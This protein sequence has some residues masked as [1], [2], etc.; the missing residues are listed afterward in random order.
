MSQAVELRDVRYT[1]P[2]ASAPVLN[3]INFAIA[4]G[5]SLGIIGHNGSGKSTL[6]RIVSTLLSAQ[7]GEVLFGGQPASKSLRTIRPRISYSAGAPLG[8]YP[9]L[10]GRENLQLFASFKESSAT[11]AQIEALLERVGLN[12][13]PNQIY[14]RYSLGMRQR[15]H[16]ARLCLP[17]FDYV[18]VDEPSNGLDHAGLDLLAE[19][20]NQDLKAATKIVISHDRTLLERVT[21]RRLELKGGVLHEV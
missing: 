14:F 18:F 1:F 10:T 21:S 15:L 20:F 19:V 3:G 2:G 4:S 13:V 16:L 17:P 12:H 7:T 6:L 5:E 11:P 9:R 8:F